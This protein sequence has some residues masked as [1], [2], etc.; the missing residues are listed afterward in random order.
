M[1]IKVSTMIGAL[2][3]VFVAGVA[4]ASILFFSQ[5]TEEDLSLGEDDS[6]FQKELEAKSKKEVIINIE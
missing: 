3:I 4:G 1:N 5:G 6:I 2:I